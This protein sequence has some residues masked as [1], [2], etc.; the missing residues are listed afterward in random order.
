MG[1]VIDALIERRKQLPATQRAV[2]TA[3]GR[4][5]SLISMWECRRRRPAADD[6]GAWAVAL[7]CKLTIQ[8]NPAAD[9]PPVLA[10]AASSTEEQLTLN[11]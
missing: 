8:I 4:A 7:G 10:S 6:L 11:Q 1:D 9:P 2:A 5:P 3:I